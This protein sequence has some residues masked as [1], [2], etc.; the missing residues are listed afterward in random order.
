MTTLHGVASALFAVQTSEIKSPGCLLADFKN[1]KM[2]T[3]GNRRMYVQ[4][5]QNVQKG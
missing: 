5:V 1:H 3:R 2:E 4:K